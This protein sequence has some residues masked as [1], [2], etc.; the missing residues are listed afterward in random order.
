MLKFEAI[1]FNTWSML[2]ATV[3]SEAILYAYCLNSS[4]EKRG[5]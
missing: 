2:L 1:L 5:F 4:C 3:C